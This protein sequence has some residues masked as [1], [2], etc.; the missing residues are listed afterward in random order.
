MAANNASL[1]WYTGL[2]KQKVMTKLRVVD[3]C[4]CLSEIVPNFSPS[5]NLSTFKAVILPDSTA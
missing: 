2:S 1:P 5:D 3:T 4:K